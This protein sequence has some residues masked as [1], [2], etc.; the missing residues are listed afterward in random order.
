MSMAY[1]AQPE[2]QE[3]R[4]WLDDTTLSILLDGAA[5][6]GNL[7]VGRFRLGEGD[8]S[9]YH[10]YSREDELFM[11]IKDTSLMW[12]GEDKVELSEGGIIS[13]GMPDAT[14]RRHVP[15]NSRSRPTSLTSHRS[16]RRM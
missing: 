9:P 7:T 4:E 15:K 10:S 14:A 2:Q 3:Q 6:D 1:V 8:A 13:S 16:H 11:M 12:C 5:T